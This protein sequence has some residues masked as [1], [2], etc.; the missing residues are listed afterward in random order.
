LIAGAQ[1]LKA[2][3]GGLTIVNWDAA[4]DTKSKK[5]SII[6]IARDQEGMTLATMNASKPHIMDQ[7]VAKALAVLVIAGFSRDL[8]L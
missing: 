4:I 6:I 7:V 2:P 8:E 1:T 3:I 5:M